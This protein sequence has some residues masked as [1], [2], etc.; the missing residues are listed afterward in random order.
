MESFAQ[1]LE[2]LIDELRLNQSRFADLVG[3]HRPTISKYLSE[4]KGYKPGFDS[5][6]KMMK[7]FPNLNGRWLILGEGEIWITDYAEQL[8]AS[9]VE[10][11]KKLLEL[12]NAKK[13]I[14]TQEKLIGFLENEIKTLRD[15]SL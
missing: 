12:E 14:D 9:L 6:Q 15:K 3:E 4:N 7:A 5:I 2:R 8:Q 10:H 11:Q 13:M 1:R